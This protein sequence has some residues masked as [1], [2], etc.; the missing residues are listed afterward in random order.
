MRETS[1]R[2]ANTPAVARSS[3]VHPIVVE[4]FDAEML[5]PERLR[6]TARKGLSREET[7]L[8][9]LLEDVLG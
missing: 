9:R 5:G 8:M 2:L 6:V 7:A 1:E 3:Y 4:A